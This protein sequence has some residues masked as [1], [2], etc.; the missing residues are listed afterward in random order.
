MKMDTWKYEVLELQEF[1]MLRI[2]A[3]FTHTEPPGRVSLFCFCIV[4]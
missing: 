3:Y 1:P 2:A 4:K